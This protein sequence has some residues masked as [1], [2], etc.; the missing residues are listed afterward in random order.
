MKL[1]RPTFESYVNNNSILRVLRRLED[2]ISGLVECDHEF[3]EIDRRRLQNERLQL[4]EI[5]PVEIPI[6]IVERIDNVDLN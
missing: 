1:Q 2:K 4:A 6:R 3:V 5:S